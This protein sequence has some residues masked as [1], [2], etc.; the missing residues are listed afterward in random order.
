MQLSIT[1]IAKQCCFCIQKCSYCATLRAFVCEEGQ[2]ERSGAQSCAQD[3]THVYQDAPMEFLYNMTHF[4]ETCSFKAKNVA[5][6][7]GI[8]IMFEYQLFKS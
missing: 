4:Q 6:E 2:P 5:E 3:G 7:N 1:A 8:V